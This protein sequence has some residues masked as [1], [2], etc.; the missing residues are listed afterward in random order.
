MLFNIT[1]IIVKLLSYFGHYT[2]TSVYTG[3]AITVLD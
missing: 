2:F 1:A 3:I